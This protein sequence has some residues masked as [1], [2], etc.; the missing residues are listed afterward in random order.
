MYLSSLPKLR[1]RYK[2]TALLFCKGFTLVE[3]LIAISIFAFISVIT[4]NGINSAIK[5]REVIS[6]SRLREAE[7]EKAV[8]ILTDDLIHLAPRPVRGA[9][10]KLFPAYSY[11]N[12]D[13]GASGAFV[14]QRNYPLEFTRAGVPQIGLAYEHG[15]QR[16]AYDYNRETQQLIR[17]VWPVLDTNRFS[18]PRI[19][20]IL[21]D[22]SSISF[23]QI[24]DQLKEHS[25]WPPQVLFAEKTEKNEKQPVDQLRLIHLPF[26]IKF[27]I[28]LNDL[29]TIERIIPGVS[30][31]YERQEETN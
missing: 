30:L 26:A 20:P 16:I 3:L 13:D 4:F 12:P 14:N 22:V 21:S 23:R 28:Q 11:N 27:A 17:I 1:I 5:T 31:P 6:K 2:H 29:G 9:S 15:L 19:Y 18:E 24:D 10:N 7:I 25:A 8:A